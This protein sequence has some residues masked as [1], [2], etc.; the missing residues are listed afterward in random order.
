MKDILVT[1]EK[2]REARHWTDY[3]LS[4]RSGIPQSVISNWFSKNQIPT[5]PNLDKVCKA[6]D[7]SMSQLFAECD[8]PIC[9]TSEQ[10]ELLDHWSYLEERQKKAL[11]QV[12]KEMK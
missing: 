2:H 1:I 3:Q 7:I 12:I 5:L 9:L 6:F 4:V 11:L 10:R 8:D